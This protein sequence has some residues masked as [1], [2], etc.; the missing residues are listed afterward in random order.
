MLNF[1]DTFFTQLFKSLD[2]NSMIMAVDESGSY[3][4]V[5]CSREYAEMM[6]GEAA[7]CIRYESAEENGAVHPEDKDEVAYLFHNQKTRDGKN[8]LTIRKLTLKGN[9]I[10]VNVHY[11]FV[12]EEGVQYAYCNYTDVTELKA[13]QQQTLAMYQELN[14]E[15]EALSSQSLAALRANLTKGVVEEVHGTDLYDMDKAGA[16][17]EDLMKIRLANMPVASDRETYLKTFDLAKLQEKYYLGEGPTSLVILSRRQSGRQCFIKYSASM[18]KDPLT[19]DVIVLGV[20]T[21]YN[22]QRVT[23]VLNDKVLARQYDMVCYIIDQN[24]GVSIGEAANIKKGSIFPKERDGIYM[25]YIRDQVLPHVVEGERE[26]VLSALSLDTI[27]ERLSGEESYS[28]DVKCLID[29]EEF[30]KRFTY[31]AV[32]QET[33]FYILLKSDMTEVIREQRERERSQT[34]HNSMVSQFNSIADESLTVV[35]SNVV[36]GLV[37]DV[38]GNDL[39]PSDYPGTTIEAYDKSRLENILID[40]ERQKYIEAFDMDMLL[41]RTEQGL[42]PSSVVCYTRRASGRQCFVKYS[43]SAS[44]NPV[45]GDIDA[46]GMEIQ[47]DSEMVSEV[48]NQKILARQYDMI[49]YL[50]SGYYA[51]TIGDAANIGKGSIFPKERNGIYMDYIHDQVKPVIVGTDE[52]KAE[53]LKELSLESIEEMLLDSEPYTVDVPCSI[54]GELFD[55]RFMFYVVD[56]E[57]HFYLL[58]KSDVTDL[59]REQRERNELLAN[60]LREAEQANVAKTAFLSSMSHEIRTPMNA[61]IGLDSIALKDPDIPE[62]TREYLTKIGGSAKHLLG[63]INDILDMSRIESGRLSIRN[64]EFSFR[65]M[66][67]QINTM[68]NGQCQDKGL[69]YDCR[70]TG[71]VDDYYIGDVMKLKQVIINILGNSVKFTLE[72]GT[73]SF[74]VEQASQYEDQVTMRFTMKDTG[75]GMDQ[76]YLPRIF[77]AFSQEDSTRSNKYGSTGLGMAITKNIVEMMNGDIA[78]ESEKGVGTTFTVSVTLKKT[79]RNA[80]DAGTVHPQDLRVLVIDDDSVACEHAKLVLEEVGIVADTAMSGAEAMEMVRLRHARQEAYNLILVDWKMPEQDGI[81]VTRKI[82]EIV[83]NDSAIIILTAYSWDDVMEEALAAGVDSFMAKPLFATGVMDEFKSAI[84]KKTISQPKQVHRA[85]LSGRH[86]LLAEDMLINAE[87]MKQLLQMRE[88]EVDHAENGQM[89]VE[90]YEKSGNNYYDAILMDV[91]MPVMDGLEATQAIRALE[92]PDAKRIPIIAMTA[93]AFDEDVQNSLQAGMNAHLSKP[94]EPEHLYET[95]E[96]LIQDDA[97][98]QQA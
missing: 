65:E 97:E 95:L 51:V 74:H 64:E 32:E 84:Q 98:G 15:L 16:P 42:G 19:G 82:R 83:G 52:E 2:N 27:A 1:K 79:D 5:W 91:R 10:W 86:I 21:E 61:I 76:E 13:S 93:N 17:I 49:T 38:R 87:I 71:L 77:E 20:E 23:E 39:Y 40:E 34:I 60:A 35:R 31:Y 50:V 37:E 66:L 90:M 63:L 62:Q 67:E 53:I 54:D 33:R 80:G 44:R 70:I 25:D 72:G 28:V 46:F 30:H 29:E 4:P 59:L 89:V 88:I 47:Y 75:I 45:T 9:E 43:G 7:D 96:T 69:T 73:V 36:T 58:L 55:K 18:R 11:A 68:I 48:M 12:K 22:S 41:D 56:R 85:E 8:S 6:E 14:K 3:Q 24:Y 94:V 81:E 57:K 26:G 78:V 92:R